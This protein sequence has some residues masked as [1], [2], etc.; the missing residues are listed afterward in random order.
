MKKALFLFGIFGAMLAGPNGYA[1]ADSSMQLNRLPAD[2]LRV[3]KDT[4][5]PNEVISGVRTPQLLEDMPFEMYVITRDEIRRHNS[6]TLVDALR[7]VPGIMVSQPGNAEMGET[8]LMRGLL[9]NTYARIFIN[10]IPIKPNGILGMPLGAQLPIRQAER[11][12]V[13]FGPAADVYGP[14]AGA[15]V[16][17]II[18]QQ[19]DRPAYADASLMVGP[20]GFNDINVTFGGKI[21][22]NRKGFRYRLY[23]SSTR[24]ND[25]GVD[26]DSP[27]FDLGNYPLD[28]V[29]IELNPNFIRNFPFFGP[30]IVPFINKQPYES[31]QLGLDVQWRRIQFSLS[32]HYRRDHSALG[33]QPAAYSYADDGTFYA[34]NITQLAISYSL[35]FRGRLQGRINANYNAYNLDPQS[36]SIYLNN[37]LRLKLNTIADLRAD[38]DLNLRDSLQSFIFEHYF[39]GRRY[40]SLSYN[41]YRSELLLFYQLR[42]W[43]QLSGGFVGSI[44]ELY[45]QGYS[46]RPINVT[47]SSF[48][49][50][51]DRFF[52]V[53]QY[54][55]TSGFVQAFARSKRISAVLGLNRYGEEFTQGAFLTRAAAQYKISPGLRIRASFSEGVQRSV[56]YYTA[57]QLDVSN[58]EFEPYPLGRLITDDYRNQYLI[59]PEHTRGLDAALLFERGHWE[60]SLSWRQQITEQLVA[61]IDATSAF[62]PDEDYAPLQ[63]YYNSPGNKKWNSWQLGLTRRQLGTQGDGLSSLYISYN[64]GTEILAD[65]TALPFIRQTPRWLIQWNNYYSPAKRLSIQLNQ[66]LV[67]GFFH[68]SL[69]DPDAVPGQSVLESQAPYYLLDFMLHFRII[70]NVDITLR[71]NNAFNVRHAGITSDRH[72]DLIFNPQRSRSTIIGLSY[73]MN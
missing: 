33:R 3:K 60:G 64:K 28:T 17:N 10:D 2:A 35:P 65:G 56:L 1:Q 67:S 21:G 54:G 52:Y 58:L 24:A 34:D 43:L 68:A 62:N 42:S 48:S 31:R 32:Q 13:L 44:N 29:G 73:R 23:G 59:T 53:S 71:T 63:R 47:E 26:F 55:Q 25:R 69:E 45:T 40:H 50:E 46:P 41:T 8:F 49:A 37:D 9:G 19:S 16:I 61:L 36:S 57:Q 20:L 14:E 5:R 4:L 11:I 6:I 70:D 38:S 18:L 7:Y 51:V 30:L 15:G 22:N 66:Q 39:S 12:E 72:D 27:A